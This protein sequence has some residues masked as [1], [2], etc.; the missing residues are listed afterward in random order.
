[1]DKFRLKTVRP[2]YTRDVILSETDVDP[3]D[4]AAAQE[5]L[6]EQVRVRDNS[7]VQE[8]TVTCMRLVRSFSLVYRLEREEHWRHLCN[9][10]ILRI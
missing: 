4:D 7:H 1:M 2:F 5:Y 3:F 10:Y 6:A 9:C 8:T